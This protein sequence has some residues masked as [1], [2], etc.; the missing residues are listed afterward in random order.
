MAK[1]RPK[2][3]R[4]SK[5]YVETASGVAWYDREQ[6]ERLRQVAADP[7]RLE[8]SYED[9][10]A[11]AERAIRDIEAT[12]LLIE[13]VPVDTEELVAWCNERG[14]PIDGEARAE[15]AAQELRRLH[16]SK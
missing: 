7:E 12:G 16:L 11:M 5:E 10:V 15:F 13:R 3:R 6:W 2:T 4:Y 8:D 1:R 9:W 14:R